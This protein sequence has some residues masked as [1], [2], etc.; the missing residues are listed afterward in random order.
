MKNDKFHQA[1]EGIENCEVQLYYSAMSF[2][3]NEFQW[4]TSLAP[5]QQV[6]WRIKRQYLFKSFINRYRRTSCL[7]M[8]LIR[9]STKGNNFIVDRRITDRQ[10]VSCFGNDFQTI[11]F[12]RFKLAAVV[13]KGSDLQSN[14]RL[15]WKHSCYPKR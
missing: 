3:V 11:S 8:F 5:T 9:R 14:F 12:G 6:V 15:L 13:G 2:G 7:N 10:C 4:L 1:Y